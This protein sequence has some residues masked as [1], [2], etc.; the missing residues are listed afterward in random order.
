MTHLTRTL[1]LIAIVIAAVLGADGFVAL[2]QSTQST[3][4]SAGGVR[5][6]GAQTPPPLPFGDQSRGAQGARRSSDVGAGGDASRKLSRYAVQ[7]APSSPLMRYN[8]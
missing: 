8:G 4:R 7:G 3:Q 2:A 1:A 6:P 5:S